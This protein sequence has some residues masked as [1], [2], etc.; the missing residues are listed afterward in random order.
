MTLSGPGAVRRLDVKLHAGD[1]DQALRSTVLRISFDGNETVLG[2]GRRLFSEA[3][4]VFLRF[5]TFYTEVTSDSLFSCFW[6]V[7]YQK[8]CRIALQNVGTDEVEA[9]LTAYTSAWKWDERSMYFGAGG[10]SSLICI[11]VQIRISLRQTTTLK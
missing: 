5:Q 9:S 10:R 7:P 8:D 2:T 11:P 4:T 1:F 3:G 6:V